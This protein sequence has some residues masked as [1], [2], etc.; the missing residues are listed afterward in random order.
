MKGV[1]LPD[2]LALVRQPAND[3]LCSLMDR[4]KPADLT[5]Q[6][7]LGLLAVLEPVDQRVNARI[8]PVL[9]LMPTRG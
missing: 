5:A 3:R 8:A 2:I 1:D 9:Q 4:V 6:E 7:I